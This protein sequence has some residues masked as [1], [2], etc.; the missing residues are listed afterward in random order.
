M[1]NLGIPKEKIDQSTNLNNSDADNAYRLR[2][3]GMLL[4]FD[5][6]MKQ[7]LFYGT[8]MSGSSL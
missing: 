1:L 7:G 5:S 4:S 3:L 2:D 6:S 8:P